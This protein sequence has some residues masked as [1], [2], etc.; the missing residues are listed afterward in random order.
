VDKIT[1]RMY[2]PRS[3]ITTVLNRCRRRET[4]LTGSNFSSPWS[5]TESA[6]SVR[7]QR[8]KGSHGATGEKS[9]GKVFYP[10]PVCRCACR[11]QSESRPVLGRTFSPFHPLRE[12]APP[13]YS[14]AHPLDTVSRPLSRSPLHVG[15][16]GSSARRRRASRGD[17]RITL[18]YI[19]IYIHNI[20]MY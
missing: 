7:V 13:P 2:T 15:S 20:N 1:Y 19:H 18:Y 5:R 4:D 9:A 11:S 6:M 8:E 16:S 17:P 12:V 14:R 10:T 3:R